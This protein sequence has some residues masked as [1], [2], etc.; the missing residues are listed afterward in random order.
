[1]DPR[2]QKGGRLGGVV[3]IHSEACW[4]D[5]EEDVLRAF[6][7]SAGSKTIFRRQKH[8]CTG[9]RECHVFFWFFVW[10]I[11]LTF[12]LT[13]WFVVFESNPRNAM[14]ENWQE[15]ARN[16]TMSLLSQITK[17]GPSL[18]EELVRLNQ[19]AGSTSQPLG[20]LRQIW[21]CIF[22]LDV[23]IIWICQ[24]SSIWKSWSNRMNN[25]LCL[26]WSTIKTWLGGHPNHPWYLF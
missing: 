20:T 23:W 25:Q 11:C 2:F 17:A 21:H 16:G 8:G 6:M 9:C 19:E 4:G 22:S 1:M 15:E 26:R 3:R 24:T 12:C 18:E 13:G 7:T 14:G 10:R 5:V